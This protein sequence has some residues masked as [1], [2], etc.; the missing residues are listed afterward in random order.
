MDAKKV[1]WEVELSPGSWKPLGSRSGTYS[2]I[3][4]PSRRLELY[5]LEPRERVHVATGRRQRLRR[6]AGGHLVGSATGGWLSCPEI[7]TQ[8]LGPF[9]S[10]FS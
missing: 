5:K 10:S 8:R 6:R 1:P 3:S 2:E 7:T 9:M 4:G